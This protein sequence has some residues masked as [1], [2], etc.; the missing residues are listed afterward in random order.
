VSHTPQNSDGLKLGDLVGHA[1]GPPLTIHQSI[2]IVIIII[3]VVIITVI[4]SSLGGSSSY[5]ITE[6]LIRINI[7]ERNNTKTRYKQYKTLLD[8]KTQ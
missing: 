7:H 5:T 4:A 6:K 2:I 8:I 1:N 3:I